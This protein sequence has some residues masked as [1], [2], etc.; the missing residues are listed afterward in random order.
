MKLTDFRYVAVFNEL[1]EKMRA[2]YIDIGHRSEDDSG[3]SDALLHQLKTG[4]IE[5][6]FE[7]ITIDKDATFSYKG[8]KV[9]VYIKD[10]SYYGGEVS[11][12]KFHFS[13]CRTIESFI[14]KGKIQKFVVSTRTDGLFFVNY[15]EPY[16]NKIIKEDILK[17][18]KVCKN[19]L[20]KINYKGFRNAPMRRRE[21]IYRNFSL[22]EFLEE[23]S[24]RLDENELQL[25][26]DQTQPKNEYPPDFKKI[27]DNF[28]KERYYQCEGCGKML[29]NP[30]KR[31]FLHAHHKNGLRWDN[32]PQNIQILCIKCHAEQTGHKH[33]KN[34]QAYFEYLRIIN[35]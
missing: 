10:Q 21:E 13:K 16:T 6:E 7:D 14:A 1:R 12:H 29:A 15:V 5:V 34:S 9:L 26:T 8:Q 24:T 22:S 35:Q 23:D 32:R 3:L 17:V 18:L 28:K 11:L 30:N 31:R 20:T 27:A 2:D 33:L 4:G 25:N 19:C